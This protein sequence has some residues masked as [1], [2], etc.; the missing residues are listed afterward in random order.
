MSGVKI[1]S[2]WDIFINHFINLFIFSSKRSILK[3]TFLVD[4]S[5]HV[6]LYTLESYFRHQITFISQNPSKSAVRDYYQMKDKAKVV[7]LVYELLKDDKR[8]LSCLDAV[9]RPG[10]FIA[11]TPELTQNQRVLKVCRLHCRLELKAVGRV[12]PEDREEEVHV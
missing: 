11:D 10:L 4:Y 1:I 7:N 8:E 2:V 5:I 9:P 12:P 6:Y 3:F